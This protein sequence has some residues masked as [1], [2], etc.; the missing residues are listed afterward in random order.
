M[1]RSGVGLLLFFCTGLLFSA[2][3]SPEEMWREDRWLELSQTEAE[4]SASLQCRVD[5]RAGALT[6]A[7]N[8]LRDLAVEQVDA[9]AWITRGRLAQARADYGLAA[10]NAL[11]AIEA[12]SERSEVLYWAA[13]MLP[14]R[15]E[16]L[17]SKYMENSAGEWPERVEGVRNSLSRRQALAGR[18]V[19]VTESRPTQLT[20]AL[21][22]IRTRSGRFLGYAVPMKL[23][24]RRRPAWALLDS[25]SPGVFLAR[26]LRKKVDHEAL[27]EETA[28]GGGGSGRQGI[29]TARL[30]KLSLGELAWTDAQVSFSSGDLSGERLYDAI[31]GFNL[32][33]GYRVTIDPRAGVLT[34]TEKPAKEPPADA[35]RF[36]RFAGQWLVE[37]EAGG[38]TGAMIFD[39][40]ASATV[41]AT[42]FAKRAGTAVRGSSRVRGFG[43]EHAGAGRAGPLTLHTLGGTSKLPGPATVDLSLRSRLGGVE[44]VGF[45]GWDVLGS[46]PWVI[47][48]KTQTIWR[49]PP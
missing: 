19:W 10:K 27:S 13:G 2:E 22:S 29:V 24:G 41:L 31:V 42:H 34:L 12:D 35:A 33:H 39:T 16:M 23:A 40:G 3:L 18:K 43:G 46:D 28:F 14:D 9:L 25:G 47:D 15:S 49:D 1:R 8:C 26:Y 5:L 48:T 36:W 20:L 37:V 38:A 17:L 21:R 4:L 45:L 11:Q 30:K 44:V 7:E 32:F 6:E